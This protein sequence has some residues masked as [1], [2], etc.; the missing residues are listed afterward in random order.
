MMQDYDPTQGA[1]IQSII[2]GNPADA[3]ITAKNLDSWMVILDFD[4]Y[5]EATDF[6]MT[7]SQCFEDTT[8]LKKPIGLITTR[9]ELMAQEPLRIARTRCSIGA[10]RVNK[11]ADVVSGIMAMA[12]RRRQDR[13]AANDGARN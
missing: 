6:S 10:K 3:I 9:G 1:L 12:L 13:E 11:Y 4:S 8:P 2:Q 7:V 5:Q